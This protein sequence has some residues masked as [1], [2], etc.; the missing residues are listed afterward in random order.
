MFGQCRLTSARILF[1]YRDKTWQ[2]VCILVLLVRIANPLLVLLVQEGVLVGCLVVVRHRVALALNN[3]LGGVQRLN[4]VVVCVGRV[5]LLPLI[6]QIAV[7]TFLILL[8]PLIRE[9]LRHQTRGLALIH[10]SVGELVLLVAHLSHL[11]A[12]VL[13]V[14]HIW[15]H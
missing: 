5:N 8:E 12:L 3:V 2:L 13:E 9:L 15:M 10:D 14:S 7:R 11:H 4:V 1:I 6:Q